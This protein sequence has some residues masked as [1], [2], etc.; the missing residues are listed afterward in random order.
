MNT[1]SIESTRAT[2]RR[3]QRALAVLAATVAALLVWVVAVPLAGVDLTVRA[4]GAQ[5]QVGPVAVGL[6]AA[7]AGLA[8]WALLALLERLTRRARAV[9]TRIA[10]V[11]LVVSLL[12]PLTRGVGAAATAT[13]VAL[14]LATAVVV[15]ALR[16]TARAA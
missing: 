13:L 4:G 8:G 3:R 2:A 16:R 1:L 14:H 6:T 7:L 5:Q 15:P 12:G 11:V 9:W 10:L